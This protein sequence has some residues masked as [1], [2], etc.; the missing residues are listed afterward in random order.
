MPTRSSIIRRRRSR[1]C[2]A[3]RIRRSHG[4]TYGQALV[5]ALLA[6]GRVARGPRARAR[7]RRG[8]RL[9]RARRDRAAARGG[10]H[11]RVHDRRARARARR[12]AAA[13]GSA[14][15]RRGSSAT[16]SPRSAARAARSI[17][18]LSQRDGRRLAREA[19]VAR[20]HRPRAAGTGTADRDKVRAVAPLADAV[21]L[22]DAPEPFYLQTGAFELDRAD[23][24]AG[25]RP[26]A[27][28][29]SPSSAI[30]GVAQA[31]DAA[32][33]PRA[34][35]ALRSPQQV[36]RGEGL[37]ASVEFVIDLLDFDRDAAGPRDDAQSLP[38]TARARRRRRRRSAEDRLHARASRAHRR[39]QARPRRRSVTALGSH[40]GPPDGPRTARVQ[41]TARDEAELRAHTCATRTRISSGHVA[42]TTS[43]QPVR[44]KS[45]VAS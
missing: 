14:T 16:C 23:R 36:A 38:R 18:M 12:R 34:V 44:R 6:Q 29:S 7:D 11:G 24:A 28:R 35:D 25:S 17:S 26:A 20:R 13:N 9:R 4:R 3:C 22:D 8:P 1:T 10:P 30:R 21:N 43:E 37:E 31:V 33:S 42:C 32:R 40:R 39:G 41:G 5:D 2:C 19:A 15:T 27:P 45:H